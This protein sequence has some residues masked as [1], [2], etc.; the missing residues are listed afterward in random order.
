M[1]FY[2]ADKALSEAADILYSLTGEELSSMIKFTPGDPKG[3]VVLPCFSL[4]KSRKKSP[5][6]ISGELANKVSFGSDSL[7]LKAES[8]GGYLNFFLNYEKFAEGVVGDFLLMKET[9]GSLSLGTGKKVVID[10]SSPNIAKPFSIGHLR[11]TNI[12][13]SLRNILSFAGYEVIGDNHLGDWGTQFGK[14][15]YAYINWGDRE[16]IEKD[17][18]KE[19][20]AL[21]V[22]FH[23]EAGLLGDERPEKGNELEESARGYFKRLEEGDPEITALWKWIRDISLKDFQRVYDMLGVSFEE[24]LGESFYND[25][26]QEIID[27]AESCG[28]LEKDTDGSEL[29]RLDKFGID[30]PLLLRKKDGASLYATRD[31]AALLYRERRWAPE[32]ILYVVGEEQRLYFNQLFETANL[33]GFKSKCE[34]VSFGLMTLPSEGKFSTRKGNVIFLEDVLKEAHDRVKAFLDGRDLDEEAKNNIADAVGIGAVKY[35]DLS[36]NRKKT[37]AFDWNKMLA[38]DGNSSPYLQYGYSRARAILRKANFDFSASWNTG[39]DLLD[40]ERNLI[41]K[42]SSFHMV[43][44]SASAQFYPHLLATWLFELTQI[45]TAFYTNVKVL[46]SEEPYRQNRLML[47]DFYSSVVKRGLA[48]LGISVLEEM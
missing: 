30:T 16:K 36:Q 47:I 13:A 42:L 7:F 4:A 44:E 31:L 22:K 6:V 26:M 43:V 39:V 2:T 28:I 21:Y 46:A 27:L 24:I 48:L 15:I 32:K 8:V 20:L 23:D 5:G 45:F 38:M 10:Y 33:L 11:S 34:H 19:L 35:N 29:V 3:D 9:Y 14:L 41:N 18:I 40:E 1:N 17:P 12:G 37:V 25:K